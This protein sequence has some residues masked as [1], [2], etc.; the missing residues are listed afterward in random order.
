MYKLQLD[1]IYAQI[2]TLSSER[3]SE[4][5]EFYE[6]AVLLSLK[7]MVVYYGVVTVADS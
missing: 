2:K 1:L 5:G 4:N 7:V 3:Y 6:E